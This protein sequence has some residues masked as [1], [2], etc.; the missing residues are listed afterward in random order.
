M[1]EEA[2]LH[3]FPRCQDF[4]PTNTE[5]VLDRL[6]SRVRQAGLRSPSQGSASG[7]GPGPRPK[8]AARRPTAPRPHGQPS[9]PL[10]DCLSGLTSFIC[11][12]GVIMRTSR[13]F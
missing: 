6:A 5:T 10:R 13:E 1:H 8:A 3:I 7:N 12:M 9:L 4:F 11:K 2:S